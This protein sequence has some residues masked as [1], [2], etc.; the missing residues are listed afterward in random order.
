MVGLG[1]IE[2]SSLTVPCD[3]NSVVWLISAGTASFPFLPFNP[4]VMTSVTT[5]L[6]AGFLPAKTGRAGLFE[7]DRGFVFRAYHLFTGNLSSSA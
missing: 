1:P 7:T 4:L 6:A 3:Q 5:V 2:S